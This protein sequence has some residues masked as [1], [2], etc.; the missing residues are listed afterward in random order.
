LSVKKQKKLSKKD[1][2]ISTKTGF[3]EHEKNTK[4]TS[5]IHKLR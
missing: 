1:S 3:E 4:T 2:K 5:P